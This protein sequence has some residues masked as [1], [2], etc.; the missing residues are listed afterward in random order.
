MGLVVRPAGQTSWTDQLDR[1]AGR[2]SSFIWSLGQ[3]AYSKIFLSVCTLSQLPSP[4]KALFFMNSDATSVVN[5]MSMLMWFMAAICNLAKNSAS[6]SPCQIYPKPHA[7]SVEQKKVKIYIL[8]PYTF[9]FPDYVESIRVKCVEK[10]LVSQR[11]NLE[12]W[13]V[14]LR[15]G[16]EKWFVSLL[17]YAKQDDNRRRLSKPLRRLTNRFLRPLQKFV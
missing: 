6:S 2:T 1:P 14:I 13:L 8:T 16:F 11:N 12:K 9:K 5:V 15:N 10:W 17:S 3:F 7:Y 4:T